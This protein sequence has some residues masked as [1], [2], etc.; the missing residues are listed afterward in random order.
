MKLQ[1]KRAWSWLHITPGIL[2]LLYSIVTLVGPVPVPIIKHEVQSGSVKTDEPAP[3]PWPNVAQAALGTQDMGL[4]AQ[5]GPDTAMPT[6]SVAKV[7][8]ALAILRQKPLQLNESGPT[9]TM[10]ANDQEI[11]QQYIALNGSV[12][13]VT[14]GLQ[15][16]QYQALQTMLLPSSNNMA[17][18]LSAWAF[19]S[20][21]AYIHYANTMLSELGFVNTKVADASGYSVNTVSTA[22]ELVKIGLLALQNP[23]IA[24]I[25]SQKQAVVPGAGE[26]ANTNAVLDRSGINGI[27][28]G[29]SD[30]AGNCLLFSATR[31]IDENP[32]TFVGVMLGGD[33]RS[34]V[35]LTAPKIVDV[36][37]ANLITV[38]PILQEQVVAK[39]ELAWDKPVDI[40]AESTLSQTVWKGTPLSLQ[41]QFLLDKNEDT[42]VITLG[43]QE[44]KA[45]LKYAIP[46]P[47]IWWRLTHPVDIVNV[48][49]KNSKI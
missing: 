42:G 8:T 2:I 44:T 37:Y 35:Q 10:T 3:V 31:I 29:T 24:Q 12:T 19:G 1:K 28:T 27:K 21:A 46:Q 38:K 17:S 32:V 7:I 14:A 33:S 25:V 9:I 45:K 20:E 23:V 4:V 5:Y 39:A 6:A 15:L 48:I 22:S 43:K 16:T 36:S 40:L 41:A 47:S 13:P 18:S 34:S 26:L 30:E 11:Y 49:F